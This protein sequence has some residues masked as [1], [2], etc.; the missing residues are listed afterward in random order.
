MAIQEWTKA[1]AQDCAPTDEPALS[2]L[3]GQLRQ[4]A[5][6]LA[7]EL[8]CVTAQDADFLR[9][10]YASTR[11]E[12]LAPT[13]W[14]DEAKHAFLAQQWQAQRSYYDQHHAQADQLLITHAEAGSIGRL[15]VHCSS[16]IRLVD[17]A[18]IPAWR[19]RGLGSGLLERLCAQADRLQRPILA[20]V[21][22]FN[23]ARRLYARLGFCIEDDNQIYLRMRRAAAAPEP[24]A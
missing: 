9:E 21:E 5:A 10:L 24:I 3:A 7:L 4:A 12:E 18:L 22:T 6:G 14:P 20:H 11:W 19:G 23:P 17:I 1:M 16:E 15:I 8:R 2:S 13:G